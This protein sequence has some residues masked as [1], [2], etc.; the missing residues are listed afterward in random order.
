MI[1]NAGFA[2]IN[3]I[4]SVIILIPMPFHISNRNLAVC[5]LF[6][7]ISF[8]C[9]FT[10]VNATV[11]QELKNPVPTGP[12]YCDVAIRFLDVMQI[13]CLGCGLAILRYLS[14]ILRSRGASATSHVNKTR[15]ALTDLAIIYTLPVLALMVQGLFLNPNRYLIQPTFGCRMALPNTKLTVIYLLPSPILALACAVYAIL[16][17]LALYKKRK[18]F[19][20]ILHMSQSGLSSARFI[21]LF[22]LAFGAL[23]FFVP[24]AIVESYQKFNHF[25]GPGAQTAPYNLKELSPFWKNDKGKIAIFYGVADKVSF[26]YY[27]FPLSAFFFTA[28]FGVGREANKAYKRWARAVGL[29]KVVDRVEKISLPAFASRMTS[30]LLSIGR[31]RLST[32][33]TSL[34]SEYDMKGVQS[35]SS[36]AGTSSDGE[37]NGIMELD[38]GHNQKTSSKTQARVWSETGVPCSPHKIKVFSEAAQSSV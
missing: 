32:S 10:A 2:A 12:G 9:L 28:M 11:W 6:A 35:I 19:Q 14:G 4:A 23:A 31:S 30:R 24:L 1:H 13:I 15:Q 34:D 38:R 5:C 25:V 20:E 37:K 22:V 21:R 17:I 27:V 7:T 8:G 3:Y 29:G 33:A 18:E 36:Q 16:I 26:L